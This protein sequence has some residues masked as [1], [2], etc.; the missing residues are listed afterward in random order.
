[1]GTTEHST[2]AMGNTNTLWETIETW[3]VT[4][5]LLGSVI[6]LLFAGINGAA[7]LTEVFTYQ[8]WISL[9][10]LI[11]RLAFL[12]GI[13]GLSVRIAT[14]SPRLGR[15]G[16]LVVLLAV[17]F[18]SGLLLLAAL[19]DFGLFTSPIIAIFGLGSVL[20]T[21]VTFVLF[22]VAILRTDAF[23]TLVGG[24]LLAAAITLVA[25]FVGLEILAI[26]TRLAGAVGE[27]IFFVILL[28]LWNVMQSESRSRDRSDTTLDSMAE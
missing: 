26:P 25:L 6:E 19:D 12:I 18:T 22:G 9:L 10:V 16:R 1:M 2:D 11:G 27:G 8:P 5:F 14:R 3:S 28:T 7:Y 21:V 20:S 13:G 4:L 17:G 24:L 15:W 23:S